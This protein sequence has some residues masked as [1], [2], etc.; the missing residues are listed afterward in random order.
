MIH[1]DTLGRDGCIGTDR[2][3]NSIPV[4]KPDPRPPTPVPPQPDPM[5]EP[6]PQ[7]D[8]LPP[9]PSPQGE[10]QPSQAAPDIVELGGPDKEPHPEVV[11]SGF[12]SRIWDVSPY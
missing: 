1:H 5:P 12:S 3:T 7:P 10:P 4:P 11:A 2:P 8:P 9:D 6:F